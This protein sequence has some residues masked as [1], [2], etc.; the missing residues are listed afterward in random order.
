[1]N[2]KKR[3]IYEKIINIVLD[4]LIVIFGIFLLISIYN[5]V[6]IK[7]LGNEYSSF[8]GYSTFEVQTGSMADTINPG[9]W[10]IVKTDK[11]IKLNDIVTYAQSGDFITHRV[12]ETYNDTFVTK[13][14]ANNSKD[15]PINKSQI[16]GKVI[17]ILPGF[18]IVRKTFF[19]PLV[20]LTLIVTLYAVSYVLRSVKQK[21]DDTEKKFDY[22][23]KIDCLVNLVLTK[24]LEFIK[25]RVKNDEDS[26]VDNNDGNSSENSYCEISDFSF[27]GVDES[28]E[29]NIEIPEISM[30]D[31][32]KTLYFRKI[33]VDKNE[34]DDIE[35]KKKRD[36][37]KENE[38]I[39]KVEE[40]EVDE[41]EE[42]VQLIQNKK[43]KFKNIVEKAIYF[44]KEEIN[45]IIDILCFDDKIHTNEPTIKEELLNAYID[46]K[47]YNHCGDINVDFNKK[48]VL[49]RI[50]N[51]LKVVGEILV[52]KYKG[53]DNKFAEKVDKFVNI[54]TLINSLEQINIKT[55]GIKEK[56]DAYRNKILKIL[57]IDNLSAVELKNMINQILRT[58]KIYQSMINYILEQTNSNV[59]NLVLK[60]IAGVKN[61]YAVSLEHNI[62][63][64]KVYSDYILDK[65][66][67]EGLIAED[68]VLIL[69]NLL[70]TNVVRDMFD[71]EE[72]KKYFIHVPN[73]IYEKPNKMDKIFKMFEDEYA[74]NNIIV[75][76]EDDSL[77]QYGKQ[78][79]SLRKKGYCFAL[80][81]NSE[82]NGDIQQYMEIVDY[83][84]VE[85]QMMSYNL[86]SNIPEDLL[87]SIIN[88]DVLSKLS[89]FGGE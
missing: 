22:K 67:S 88:D 47:F 79:S 11:N 77:V 10:I 85:K 8:F 65:T 60:N 1:M 81:L 40:V 44:K 87:E 35:M 33:T 27:G 7:I 49:S 89:S 34:L 53:S 31:M 52:N 20:L 68:K 84:F 76:V 30:E 74:K 6:Q 63:F 13:G 25:K 59:F 69:L 38:K 54:F 32:D 48:T 5:N 16:V 75:V 18:G 36:A 61:S 14:D 73:S 82:I 29:I 71:I 12:V 19:N 9:D 23:D 4:V 58:Q 72:N 41:I 70:L 62:L 24:L 43:K 37:E 28:S 51:E 17:K 56:R 66:Y 2:L 64:S 55:S 15:D 42:K 26:N 3:G 80:V 45:E 57:K 46:G 21:N 78:I 50:D 83:L 39:N 86:I